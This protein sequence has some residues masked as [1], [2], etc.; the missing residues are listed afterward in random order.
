VPFFT[1]YLQ[2]A[3]AHACNSRVKNDAVVCPPK[4]RGGLFTTA[5][6]DNIDHNPSST[7][8]HDSFHGTAISLA[9]HPTSQVPGVNRGIN[10]IQPIPS[11]SKVSRKVAQL[12]AHFLE[13]VPAVFRESEPYAPQTARLHPKSSVCIRSWI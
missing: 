3:L 12:P 13:V 1:S 6:V 4:L 9:Q 10:T 7:S 2:L 8:A 11:A 5:A